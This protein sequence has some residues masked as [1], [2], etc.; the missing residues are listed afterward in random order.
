MSERMTGIRLPGAP[1]PGISDWGRRTPSEMI[2]LARACGKHLREQADAIAN[3]ADADFL[4]E[5]YLGPIAQRNREVLQAA[6]KR[7]AS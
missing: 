5:T 3:A 2:E 6:T 7:I 1:W 4:V